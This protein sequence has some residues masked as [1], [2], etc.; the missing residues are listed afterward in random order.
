MEAEAKALIRKYKT[1]HITDNDILKYEFENKKFL[2][3]ILYTAKNNGIGYNNIEVDTGI[4]ID[5]PNSTYNIASWDFGKDYE[6]TLK[7]Y[8]SELSDSESDDLDELFTDDLA[9][10]FT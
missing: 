3:C 7:S 1:I 8:Y 6:W 2:L 4:G 5:K 9:E 10:L